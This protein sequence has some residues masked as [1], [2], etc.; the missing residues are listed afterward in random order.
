MKNCFPERL[1]LLRSLRRITQKEAARSLHLSPGTLS[2]YENG[3]HEPD[4]VT[5]GR[6]A[7]LYGVSTDYLLGRT[8]SPSP[9]A[10]ERLSIGG[11]PLGR[12]LALL[13]LLTDGDMAALAH[14]LSVLEALRGPERGR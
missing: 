1:R 6:L 10:T 2:N 9:A 5:L 13:P 3:V 8:P 11:Y 14:L 7:D 12:L 4:Y